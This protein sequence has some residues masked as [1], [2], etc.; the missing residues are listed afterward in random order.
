MAAADVG[1]SKARLEAA[2]LASRVDGLRLEPGG[3]GS[4]EDRESIG[5]LM[6]ATWTTVGKGK[7]SLK[8]A[9]RSR[10][11]DGGLQVDLLDVS[12]TIVMSPSEPAS[13][14]GQ[15]PVLRNGAE[16]L[17]PSARSDHSAGQTSSHRPLEPRRQASDAESHVSKSLSVEPVSSRGLPSPTAPSSEA[18]SGP[19]RSASSFSL[20]TRISG[21]GRGKRTGTMT[22]EPSSRERLKSSRTDAT[23]RP[24]RSMRPRLPEADVEPA[25][26]SGMYWSLAPAHGSRPPPPMRSH[27][28]S[29]VGDT[30]WVIGGMAASQGSSVETVGED[31]QASAR[32]QEVWQ[33][34][35]DTFRWSRARC[36][37]DGPPAGRSHSATVVDGR[38]F[39][40]GG[41]DNVEYTNDLYYLDTGASSLSVARASF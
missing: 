40:F 29:L 30:I 3:Y 27:T 1:S 13:A 39:V 8:S 33:L 12:P 22:A 2:S 14:S 36:T 16:T 25:P 15:S 6:T 35:A 7:A 41:G 38:I 4:E 17:P 11:A 10:R 19:Q 21:D 5:E 32:A 9:I 20:G 34:D 18:P 37:G 31:G 26:A 23:K 28:A 24:Q